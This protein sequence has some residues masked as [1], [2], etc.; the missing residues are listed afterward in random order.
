MKKIASVSL[1]KDEC[2]IIELFVRINLRFVDRMFIID[3][4][5]SDSTATIIRRLQ[6]EGC[7]VTLW[8]DESVDFQQDHTTTMAVHRV[9]DE[10]GPDWIIP[11]D[12]DEFLMENGRGLRN[13]L[14]ELP[15]QHCGYVE[16]RTFVPNS[17]DYASFDNPLWQNFRQRTRETSPYSKVVIPAALAKKSSLSPGNHL[18][19]DKNNQ[20]FPSV[21]L[22]TTLAHVPVR[23]SEQIVAKSIIGSIKHQI[24]WNRLN[25]EGFHK[26]IMAKFVRT[27]NYRLDTRQLQDMAF[28]YAQM[29]DTEIIRE[30]DEG[31]RIGT[32]SDSIRYRELSAINLLERFD[33]FMKELGTEL[34][35]ENSRNNIAKSFTREIE[36]LQEA[37]QK[38]EKEL[39]FF[40]K[41]AVGKA[42]GFLARTAYR[43][44]TLHPEK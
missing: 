20:C 25:G 44:K 42:V 6:K 1:V 15:E 35:Q 28:S 39:R 19:L 18:L 12:A 26:E 3:N 4:R 34:Q 36:K 2:D 9:V 11:L 5:S 30:I 16:W 23:S 29:P 33:S 37:L 40:R 17:G 8:H 43:R 41:T 13:E 21:P 32:E 24:T 7:P 22:R 27:C 14:E 31:K 10:Y 38:K